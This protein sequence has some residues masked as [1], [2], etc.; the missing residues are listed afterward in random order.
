M[1]RGSISCRKRTAPTHH[2]GTAPHLEIRPLNRSKHTHTHTHTHHMSPLPNP[3]PQMLLTNTPVS[4]F[5]VKSSLFSPSA[6]SSVRL[7]GTRVFLFM[8]ACKAGRRRRHGRRLR[9][10]HRQRRYSGAEFPGRGADLSLCL[11]IR[12]YCLSLSLPPSLS[13]HKSAPRCLHKAAQGM[14]QQI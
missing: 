11:R 14:T 8:S 9:S 5:S 7:Y 13:L 12:F 6:A 10:A 1:S 3:N 2:W 4:L